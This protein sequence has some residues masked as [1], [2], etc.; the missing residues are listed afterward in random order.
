MRHRLNYRVGSYK[1]CSIKWRPNR[2]P[3]FVGTYS[4]EFKRN[5]TMAEGTS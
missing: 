4:A 1:R 5:D 2:S 3:F